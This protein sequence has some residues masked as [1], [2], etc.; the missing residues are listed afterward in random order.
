MWNKRPAFSDM[1]RRHLSDSTIES[2]SWLCHKSLAYCELFCLFPP[3]EPFPRHR[4]IWNRAWSCISHII[5]GCVKPLQNALHFHLLNGLLFFSSINCL[6]CALSSVVS[7]K[8]RQYCNLTSGYRGEL[9]AWQVTS[10]GK[11]VVIFVIFATAL[12]SAVFRIRMG[13]FSKDGKFLE[14][15]EVSQSNCC[16]HIHKRLWLQSWKYIT[17]SNSLKGKKVDQT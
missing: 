7:H 10:A 1:I 2:D 13:S 14:G 11:L 12:W 6:C 4:A 3:S 8:G 16:T 17:M 15:R 5:M 9:L